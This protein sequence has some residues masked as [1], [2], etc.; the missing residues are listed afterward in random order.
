MILLPFTIIP[1]RRIV[2][3]SFFIAFFLF[4]AMF[5]YGR[6]EE[7]PK[8]IVSISAGL[9]NNQSWEVEPFVTYYF[10]KF[11]GATLG[12]NVTNLYNEV[13]YAGCVIENSELYWEIEDGEY[14]G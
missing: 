14:G 7:I 9:S 10:C 1:E 12:L 8:G 13:G 3:G 5:S 4:F 2:N 6:E 11:L